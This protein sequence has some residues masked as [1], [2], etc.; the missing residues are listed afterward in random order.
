[1]AKCRAGCWPGVQQNTQTARKALEKWAIV[2]DRLPRPITMEIEIIGCEGGHVPWTDEQVT[3]AQELAANHL[4]RAICLAD[5]TGRRGSD[6]IRMRW[7][8]IEMVG[9]RPGIN[10]K[11]KKT[12]LQIWVPFT[13]E[14]IEKMTTWSAGPVLS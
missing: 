9:G 1:V 12:K 5:N 4:A 13:A 8:D 11:Q 7:T 3:V 2:R 6:T 10:V 14:L